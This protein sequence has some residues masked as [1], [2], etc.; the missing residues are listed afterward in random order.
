M[1][2]NLFRHGELPIITSRQT[3]ANPFQNLQEQITV[4]LVPEKRAT[5]VT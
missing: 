3:P 4:S 1:T 2:M 5:S